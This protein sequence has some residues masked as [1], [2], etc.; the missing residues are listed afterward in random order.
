MRLD[1]II[2]AEEAKGLE[3]HLTSLLGNEA[4]LGKKTSL[5]R[6]LHPRDV[7]FSLWQPISITAHEKA[8]FDSSKQPPFHTIAVAY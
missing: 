1:D 7:I 4:G 8:P 2:T 5:Q 6:V 3:G